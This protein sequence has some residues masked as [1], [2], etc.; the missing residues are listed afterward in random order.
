MSEIKALVHDVF[1]TVVDWRSAVT[2]D[3]EELG[4]RKGITGVDWQQ[5]AD[6]WRGAYG[7]SMAR[8][9]TGEL[10]WTN[11]DALHRMGLDVLLDKVGIAGKL[12]EEDKTWFNLTWHRLKPWPDSVPG[13]TRIKTKFII[14]TLSN[15][16]VRLLTDMAKHCGLPWDTVLGSDLVKAYKPDAAMYQSAIEFLG[17][18]EPGA[19]MMV[20]AHNSDLARAAELGMKTAYIARPYE[21]GAAQSRDFKAE[22]DFTYVASGFEDLA[23]QLGC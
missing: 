14:A 15:G 4:R 20:A 18:G 17:S 7:P 19:V 22:H 2:A 16:T 11:L 13:L 5:F 3:G 10:P 8:V 23:T 9:R 1:G 21:R 12:S 6:E